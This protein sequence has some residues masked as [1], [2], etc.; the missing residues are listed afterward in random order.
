MATIR[1]VTE[2]LAKRTDGIARTGEAYASLLASDDT[3]LASKGHSY[4]VYR[5]ALRD[6]QCAATFAQR[7]LGV[8]SRE[9]QVDPASES[10]ADKAAADFIREQ[11]ARLEWDRITDGMLYA[12]WYGH[13]VAECL[14]ALDGNRVVLADIRVRDRSRFAYDRD[15]KLYLADMGRPVEMPERK[16]WTITTGEDNDDSPYGLGL[17]HYCYWPV[18]FKR[19]GIRFWLTFAEKFGMPTAVG[20]L[21]QGQLDD[22]AFRQKALQALQAIASET[23]VL[24]PANMEVE[25]LEATRGGTGT[26]DAL[27]DA[28]D[29]AIAKVV[30]GQTASSEGTPG[31]LGNDKLQ[32]TVRTD[33][34]K[35]DADLVC[36]SFNRQVVRWLTE[37]NF[38][39]AQPPKVWRVVEPPEDLN[40]RADRD[41]KIF[42]LGFEPTEDYIRETYGDGWQKKAVQAGLDPAAVP[43]QLAA[44]FAELGA[45]SAM[46]LGHRGDQAA[47]AEAAQAF[48]NRYETVLGERVQQLLDF[49]ETTGDYGEF[50]RG[51]LGMMAEAPK[52]G[53]ASAVKSAGFFSR[54]LG[55][56][57]Q[58]RN[59]DTKA[60]VAF[61]EQSAERE[62]RRDAMLAAI[63][64]REAPAPV[65]N[66]TPAPVNVHVD[67][68]RGSTT[69]QTIDRDANGD[70]ARITTTED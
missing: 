45:L 39:G 69:T 31:R 49:A 12:R 58:Q 24:V 16:F 62:A 14:W 65:V 36:G 26:Y 23:A 55:M 7:R 30:V 3:I 25:L 48:A 17:A 20:K 63:A 53:T 34:L 40:Q 4:R 57:R 51:L 50:Q 2:E 59:D 11:L 21:S 22:P 46:K 10:A 32:S 61:A 18:Y 67:A 70:V 33:L 28:M 66:V 27:V 9:W 19:N 60:Q 52:T 13:A 38:P 1:P 43:G 6:D 68:R 5:E 47:I 35:A 29:A 44:E 56:F 37:W 41:A 64:F 15:G 54:M 42:G 8:T